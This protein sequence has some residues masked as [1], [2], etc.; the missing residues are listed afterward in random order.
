MPAEVA[1]IRPAVAGTRGMNPSWGGKDRRASARSSGRSIC[2]N[3]HAALSSHSPSPDRVL[4]PRPA[5][6]APFTI[7][8]HTIVASIAT[9]SATPPF[10]GTADGAGKTFSSLPAGIADRARRVRLPAIEASRHNRKH[11]RR[12]RTPVRTFLIHPPPDLPGQR[13]D[14]FQSGSFRVRFRNP[15][16]IIRHR[17]TTLSVA[18]PR[19]QL[20]AD[21]SA[22]I[23]AKRVLEAVGRRL[24]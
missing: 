3:W 8:R 13:R 15:P 17:Q 18:H 4:V 23:R 9:R 5:R 10:M 14:E 12:G 19:D 11:Q 22:R 16:A 1:A 24:I 21:P 7:Y 2:V 6:G 20:D